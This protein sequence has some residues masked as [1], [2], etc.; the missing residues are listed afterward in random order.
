MGR[1]YRLRRGPHAE[2]RESVH[3]G[4]PTQHANP[5]FH[6]VRYSLPV[7]QRDFAQREE[8]TSYDELRIVPASPDG[9]KCTLYSGDESTLCEP[10]PQR[11]FCS[12]L[13][14]QMPPPK[15]I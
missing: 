6:T 13:V 5:P 14:L 12:L 4:T 1:D 3:E 9:S 15:P 10:F 8:C 11:W 7:A 2:Q